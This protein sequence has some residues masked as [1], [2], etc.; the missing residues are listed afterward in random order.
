MT[1][2]G[3]NTTS[4]RSATIAPATPPCPAVP[5]H[6][7][8]RK[9]IKGAAFGFLGSGSQLAASAL[10]GILTARLLGSSDK[11]ALSLALSWGILVTTVAALGTSYAL[12]FTIS[13]MTIRTSQEK[14]NVAEYWGAA[15]CLAL[16]LGAASLALAIPLSS[17]LVRDPSAKLSVYLALCTVP[18]T[19]IVLFERSI[20]RGLGLYRDYTIAIIVQAVAWLTSVGC[21]Y[22]Y[23]L[24][25]PELIILIYAGSM[26][27]SAAIAALA[28][29]R[30]VGLPRMRTAR[31]STTLLRTGLPAW[32]STIA[33]SANRGLDQLVLG[34]VSSTKAVGIYAVA[35]SISAAL[36]PIGSG[37]AMMILPAVASTPRNSQRQFVF[38]WVA[39][40]LA[41]SASAA[42][43][44]FVL[45]S[46]SVELLFGK[47][48]RQSADLLAVLLPAEVVFGMN[49]VLH[50]AL[51]GMGHAKITAATETVA[52][53]I[54]IPI[55]M[56]ASNRSGAIGAAWT[57]LGTYTVA[58]AL[59][60]WFLLK[61][62]SAR[63]KGRSE[64]AER[65]ELTPPAE[66][67]ARS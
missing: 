46:T 31:L 33:F 53:V 6:G 7:T 60:L 22:A 35:V 18:L 48:F 65:L 58:G 63:P 28:L 52:M 5:D 55:L 49:F 13:K 45:R 21:A 15:L 14:R 39:C 1:T 59:L 56:Y 30:H 44:L 50:D 12:T 62:T 19:L 25:Q 64:G 67:I 54:M 11:G 17:R 26:A 4:D 24:R 2:L 34:S 23:N 38:R 9:S 8:S 43:L 16:I 10:A 37:I 3:T 66:S 36:S 32:I 29:H 27:A 57:S 42:L 40:T 20:L 51:R 41:L 47:D 61:R